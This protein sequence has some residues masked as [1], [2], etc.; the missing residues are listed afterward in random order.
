MQQSAKQMLFLILLAL[1]FFLIFTG[2]IISQANGNSLSPGEF[3]KLRGGRQHVNQY[4]DAVTIDS[5][6]KIQG[7]V[8]VTGGDLTLSG[9]VYGDVMV[10]SGNAILKR[11][12]EI[13]GHVIVYQGEIFAKSGAKI[14]GDMLEIYGDR[15]K[16]T[17]RRDIGGINKK[18]IRYNRQTT[19]RR[20]ENIDGNIVVLKGDVQIYG[21]VNGDVIAIDGKVKLGDRALVIGHIITGSGNTYVS[22]GGRCTGEILALKLDHRRIK[23]ERQNR[24][25]RIESRDEEIRKRV[26]RKYLRREK[27]NDEGIFR[28]FG[29][30]TVHENETINGHVVTMK[31][32]VTLDG[33]VDGDVIAVFG[34]IEMG[35]NSYVNGD[36]VSVG[37]K[38][39]RVDGSTVTGDVVETSL[40]GVRV[41]KNERSKKRSVGRSSSSSRK[42]GKRRVYP[43]KYCCD[44]SSDDND[45]ALFRYNRVEGL[46]LGLKLPIN[47][48]RQ[49][50]HY[51]L[52]LY[53]HFGYGFSNK[54][55]RYRLGLER[56]FF[57][58]LRFTLG[59]QMYDLTE[60]QDDWLIP[61][62]ENSLA[63]LFLKEDFQDFYC[64]EGY[65]VY[66][67]QNFTSALQV[68]AEYRIDRFYD[69]TCNTQW[70]LFGGHKQFKSNPGVDPIRELKSVA[71]K[72]EIDTRNSRR[73]P[74]QGWYI[75]FEG[76]FAGPRLENQEILAATKDVINFDRYIL[77]IRRYQPLG[78]GENLDIRLRGGSARGILPRQF[79]FDM[80]GLSSLR[81][82]DYKFFQNKDRMVLAN[83]EYRIHGRRTSFHDIWWFEHFNLIL[84][85]DA[86]LAWNSENKTSY[87][88]GFRD[89]TWSALKTD[90]GLAITN[91]DGDVRL[92]IAK[93]TDISGQPV[94]VTF[95]LNRAF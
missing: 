20:H 27:R 21:E 9:E 15:T 35:A 19:I 39:H 13:Y 73:H 45:M 14:A 92:N 83:I 16:H 11:S 28:F 57:D 3:M 18:V 32:H 52:A 55:I 72:V 6:E 70:A 60:S 68:S 30:V 38:I 50:T 46:F 90:I 49:K 79:Q 59:A 63:A 53:G 5:F 71:A 75:L 76:Q 48:W 85:A 17:K 93:R 2:L 47:Y 44:H 86:G 81:G 31:G 87:Q 82:Y 69:M 25:A 4:D 66:A 78:Y 42:S 24:T 41:R 7:D 1:A 58:D 33:E 61:G 89:L 88:E 36:V 94:V 23:H 80:G 56:W 26:E 10:F 95:R 65:S 34:D 91:F 12:A 40:T 77:D 8:V 37:G 62:L 74:S 67:K 64:R 54:E 22:K 29:D 84:F 43:S 51:N